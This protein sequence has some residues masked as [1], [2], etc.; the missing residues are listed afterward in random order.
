MVT[1]GDE[2]ARASLAMER[3]QTPPTKHYKAAGSIAGAE[4]GRGETILTRPGLTPDEFVVGDGGG[5]G[6]GDHD[7][8]QRPMSQHTGQDE[9]V[10]AHGVEAVER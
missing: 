5:W 8:A 7:I 2:W 9:I 1:G 4:V 3:T 10:K 6:R